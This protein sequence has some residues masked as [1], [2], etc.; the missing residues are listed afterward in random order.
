M[1]TLSALR[2]AWHPLLNLYRTHVLCPPDLCPRPLHSHSR[3]H[4]VCEEPPSLVG[5][6]RPLFPNFKHQ[7]FSQDAC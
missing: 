6:E 7:P 1:A 4:P 2:N 3:L 5:R